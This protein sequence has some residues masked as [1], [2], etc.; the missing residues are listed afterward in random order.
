MTR[1]PVI[2][3][4]AHRF[5]R[6]RALAVPTLLLSLVVTGCGTEPPAGPAAP[7]SS[8]TPLSLPSA[9]PDPAS[10]AAALVAAL[11]DEDLVG[12]V[13]MPYA[14][15]ASAT[16]VSG[17]SKAGNRGLAGVDT[18]AQM[19]EKYRLG[20]LILVGFSADDPT[21]KNQPTTNVDNP[22]QV[23]A[24]TDGLQAAQAKLPAGAAPMLIGTDQE[25]GVVTRIRSGV[26]MLPAAMAFGAA[27]DIGATEKAWAV[28]GGDLAAMGINTD[29]APVA[30]VLGGPGGLVIGSRSY[31]DQPAAVA[32]QVSAAVRGLQSGGVAAALK[33]FP[34][35]GHTTGDSHDLLPVLNQDRKTLGTGDLPPFQAGIDAGAD[36]VMSGHLDVRAIDP[37]VPASFSS[38]VLIDLLRTEMKFKGVVVSDALNMEPAM[39]WPAGEAA[40]RALNAGNDLLLMPPDLPAAHAGLLAALR[41]GS[42]TRAR[43]TE[44]VTRVL[45]LRL[46]LARNATPPVTEV[47]ARSGAEPLATLAARSIT[48]LRGTCDGAPL[49][50]PVTVTAADGRGESKKT[51][52]EA[53]RAAGV[54][55]AA[56]GG[57]T[58]VHLVG[59]GDGPADLSSGARVTVAMHLPYLLASSSSPVLMATYSSSGAQLTAL[60]NVLAGKAKPQ[61]SSP[62]EVDGLPRTVC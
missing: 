32:E 21:G 45:T 50:G 14:Y 62:V 15:G 29:F 52:E 11:K 28:A 35:H 48:M 1:V 54:Q 39:A 33:H 30:D 46:T 5:G 13:L 58:T 51:L 24:L 60:A 31:G 22:A 38:K 40:V 10:Q 44:A 17:G 53:L 59:Y 4:R 20:G 23:R 2:P 37:G 49:A 12:Q 41:D 27:G 56:S 55:V 3:S 7:E 18:P 43:L 47:G 8:A 36:L 26:N 25:Y 34:G 16:E 9:A 19:V 57:Q 61:G 42:L 6:W